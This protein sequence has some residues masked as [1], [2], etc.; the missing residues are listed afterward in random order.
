MEIEIITT[1]KKLT[2]SIVNQMQC[3][4]LSILKEGIALGFMI[5]IVKHQFKT[6]LIQNNKKYYII[7]TNYVQGATT[8]YRR[9]KGWSQKIEFKTPELCNEWWDVY[10][11]LIDKTIDQIYI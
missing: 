9:Y 11:T 7:A 2:K 1:K 10:Q 6:I 3:P 4:S 8:V 5:G